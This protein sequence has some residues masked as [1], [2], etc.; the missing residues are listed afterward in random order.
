MGF[1]SQ[2]VSAVVA[3]VETVTGNK[4]SEAGDALEGQAAAVEQAASNAADSAADAASE[5]ADFLLAVIVQETKDTTT[6]T[7]GDWVTGGLNDAGIPVP[8]KLDLQGTVNLVVA[9]GELTERKTTEKLE[10]IIG[11]APIRAGKSI[12]SAL[13]REGPGGAFD[14]VKGIVLDTVKADRQVREW[15]EHAGKVVSETSPAEAM[16]ELLQKAPGGVVSIWDAIKG[17][18]GGRNKG[19]TETGAGKRKPL[20]QLVTRAE[21]ERRKMLEEL[22]RAVA[23]LERTQP[24]DRSVPIGLPTR[25]FAVTP[26]GIELQRLIQVVLGARRRMPPQRDPTVSRHLAAATVA[27]IHSAVLHAQLQLWLSTIAR[28]VRVRRVSGG[29]SRKQP[30]SP[31]LGSVRLPQTTALRSG[32]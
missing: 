15:M 5:A 7:V 30:A 1:L 32:R 25:G 17:L 10:R 21:G 12:V 11:P 18:V 24:V 9:I 6:S 8:D 16:E 31:S 29:P 28:L 23:G 19:G 14:V 22:R 4:D 27:A 26:D 13:V 20:P 3:A 2:L